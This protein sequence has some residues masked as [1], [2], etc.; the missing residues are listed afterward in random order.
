MNTVS[1]NIYTF[2]CIEDIFFFYWNQLLFVY[3][4]LFFF[5]WKYFYTS[6]KSK[7]LSCD[8]NKCLASFTWINI[9]KLIVYPYECYGPVGYK[10]RKRYSHEIWNNDVSHRIT[11]NNYRT[12]KIGIC[13]HDIYNLNR[14]NYSNIKLNKFAKKSWP[15]EIQIE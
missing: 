14:E 9:R 3:K 5:S 15:L 1:K 6:Y 11:K 8:L 13:V 7:H 2:R 12:Y 10:S 4:I